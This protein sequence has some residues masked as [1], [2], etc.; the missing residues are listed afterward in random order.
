MSRR[1]LHAT[2]LLCITAAHAAVAS[3]LLV[4]FVGAAGLLLVPLLLFSPFHV[5]LVWTL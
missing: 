4:M 2:P 3:A 5:Y 1:S